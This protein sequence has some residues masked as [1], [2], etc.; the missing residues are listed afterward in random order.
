M[1]RIKVVKINNGWKKTVEGWFDRDK[2]TEI[3]DYTNECNGSSYLYKN[4]KILLATAGGKLV[5][6]EWDNTGTNTYRLAEDEDEIAEILMRAGCENQYSSELE[7]LLS[8]YE[9]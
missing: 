4:G 2:A 7:E 8:K 6:N 1:K 3:A 9:L 5:V